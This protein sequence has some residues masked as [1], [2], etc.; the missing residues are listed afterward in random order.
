MKRMMA[1][2]ILVIG[3]M[4]GCSGQ[5][6]SKQQEDSSKP[7]EMLEV[8]IEIVPETINPNEEVKIKAIVT[9][10]KEKVPDANEVKFEIAKQGQEKHELIEA[11]NEGKGVYSI[12]KVFPEAGQYSVTSHVTARDMHSMPNKEFT[13]GTQAAADGITS[14]DHGGEHNGE[15]HH[16]GDLAIEFNKGTGFNV[17]KDTVLSAVVKHEDAPLTNADVKFEVWAG[18]DKNHEWIDAKE[19]ENGVYSGSVTFKKSGTHHVQIHVEK[20]E[21]HDHKVEMFDVN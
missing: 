17:N 9:Q 19:G 12:N 21:I 2:I 8:A 10:G 5:N 14:D 6:G 16:G 13:V 7:Q 3:L 4:A 1:G 15:H 20:D 11:K 18:E